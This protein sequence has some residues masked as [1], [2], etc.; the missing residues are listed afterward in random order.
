MVFFILEGMGGISGGPFCPSEAVHRRETLWT[1]RDFRETGTNR[2]KK[3]WIGQKTKCVQRRIEDFS[4]AVGFA[5]PPT[6]R[7][8]FQLPLHNGAAAPFEMEGGAL[9][10]P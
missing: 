2:P 6:S 9:S 10:E 3:E 7:K 8:P 5:S 1:Q 4:A